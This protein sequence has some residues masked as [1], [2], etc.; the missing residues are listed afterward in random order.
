M[1]ES[2]SPPRLLDLVRQV[3]LTRFGQDGPA[4]CFADWTGRL[5]LFHDER[6]P[7]ELVPGDVGRFLEHV[8]RT[9]PDG[10]NGLEKAHSALIFL[11][12]GTHGLARRGDILS[13]SC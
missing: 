5:I 9:E 12:R 6:H 2:P 11:Y 4:E 10:L 8:A 7:R 3:A 13:N 1:S